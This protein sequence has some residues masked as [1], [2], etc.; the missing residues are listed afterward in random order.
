MVQNRIRQQLQLRQL[1]HQVPSAPMEPTRK[2]ASSHAGTR[3]I[4][5]ARRTSEWSSRTTLPRASSS[6]TQSAISAPSA[7][8]IPVSQSQEWSGGLVSGHL[9]TSAPIM[10]EI[11]D[12]IMS[13]V[14]YASPRRLQRKQVRLAA[15][16]AAGEQRG[17]ESASRKKRTEM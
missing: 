11:P 10:L 16:I 8:F 12:A 2:T 1:P 7:L 3:S 6:G 15:M 9:F 13:F 5:K 17:S 14:A 4:L